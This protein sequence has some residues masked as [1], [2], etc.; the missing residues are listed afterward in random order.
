MGGEQRLS[1]SLKLFSVGSFSFDSVVESQKKSL[2]GSLALVYSP[3]YRT[4]MP[5][6]SLLQFDNS[7]LREIPTDIEVR[8]FRRE[9]MNACHSRVEPTAVSSPSLVAYSREVVDLLELSEEECMSDDFAAVFSGS[10][11]VEGMDPF[12][13]CYG[14]HQF[15]NW[16]GQLGDGRAIS[17]G[18]VLNS[19]GERWEL[20]LKGAG[21]TPYSRR[22]DGRAVMRSSVREFLC[23]EAMFH[24]GVPT[25]RALSLIH[26]GEPVVRDLLY[27]GNPR[28]EPGAIVCRVA[29]TFIRFGH[30]EI[31]S[32][33][34]EVELLQRLV[35]YTIFYHFPHLGN[36]SKQ[37]YLRWLS[38]VSERTAAMI[39]DWMRVGFVHGVMNT[40]NMSI[41]GQTIDYGPYGWLDNY[42]ENWTP[43][44]TDSAGR[45]YR[46]GNQPRIAFWNLTQLA[47]AL[48]PLIGEVKPLEESI[49]VFR[50]ALN[51]RHL[52]MMRDKLG[53]DE[54]CDPVAGSEAE[55]SADVT[56]INELI[57]VLQL[58][59]T[60][61]TI[62]FR[63]LADW[64]VRFSGSLG[65][66]SPVALLEPLKGAFYDFDS[67]S[68]VERDKLNT[69]LRSYHKRFE[70]EAKPA[71]TRRVEMNKVNPKYV[72]RNYIAQLAIEKAEKGDGALV[73]ELLE[74][75]RKPYDEQPQYEKYA[76]KRPDWARNRPGCSM[77]SCSS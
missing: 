42:D 41:L 7:F 65:S 67:L 31:I 8:N 69:W 24:L 63:R 66:V 40:D 46:Y 52:K 70:L 55:K 13:S 35:D 1:T 4:I 76:K 30:F 15:G 51:S 16:A 74:V 17:L 25:T 49:S 20:Q 72:L 19:R 34:G 60:D 73:R 54:S 28:P 45:R 64:Q 48:Y 11:L 32:S 43:N 22:G 59:E 39:V 61:M 27:D 3:M 77:L 38:E 56:L 47:N 5:A 71:Q 44:T 12:A 9:V 18:E 57:R 6:L 2:S 23:S 68:D 75:F 29:P 37:T 10:A 53:L 33:R 50:D 58:K 36:P 21:P 26:S 62:F 14:G